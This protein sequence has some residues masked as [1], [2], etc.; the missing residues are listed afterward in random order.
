LSR[1]TGHFLSSEAR[2]RRRS[3]A[4]SSTAGRPGVRGGHPSGQDPA[5]SGPGGLCGGAAATEKRAQLQS[6]RESGGMTRG[7]PPDIAVPVETCAGPS[8]DLFPR[9]SRHRQFPR[10]LQGPV[11]FI[12]SPTGLWFLPA[13]KIHCVRMMR[14]AVTG[15]PKARALL[16]LQ[17][18]VVRPDDID[19]NQRT[20]LESD[21]AN[22]GMRFAF[23]P[24]APKA[25]WGAHR[26]PWTGPGGGLGRP[27]RRTF[28]ALRVSPRLMG[29]CYE[30]FFA[31]RN[32]SRII[33]WLCWLQRPSLPNFS[34]FA[35]GPQAHE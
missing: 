14:P 21:Q 6:L 23:P 26:A 10:G 24:Y 32:L 16:L 27:P 28:H 2:W 13:R 17:R 5:I 3:S 34:C 15:G 7:A 29:N 11:M 35:G 22:G 31:W 33:N 12:G 20:S 30:K 1:R 18:T 9:L 25:L 8:R 4:P 19:F